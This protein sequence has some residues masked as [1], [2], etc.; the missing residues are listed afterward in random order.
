MR[1]LVVFTLVLS[2]ASAQAQLFLDDQFTVSVT[3][4]IVYGTGAV[5]NPSPGFKNLLLDLY[6]PAGAGVPALKPGFV[7]I[8]GGGFVSGDKSNGT[9]VAIANQF[10]RR[11]YVCVSIN[12]RLQGDDPP[13]P[14]DTPIERAIVAAIEDAGKAVQWMR[15]NAATYGIDINRIALGGGSAGAITSLFLGYGEYG[16]D[17]AVQAIM[18]LW[19]GL[20]GMESIVDANDPPVFI[21][22]GTNDAVVPYQ[23]SLDL[24]ARLDDVG[25]DYEFYPIAGAGHGVSLNTVVDGQTL[26]Q[27][28]IQFMYTHVVLPQTIP[29]SASDWEIFQ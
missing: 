26:M 5:Q 23:L 15:N 7:L 27:R 16:D 14:G 11:G 9:M 17:V 28:L 18:D 20:Y 6:E 1:W 25:L 21:V 2:A 3:N 13:T 22:H 4:D 8:H 12:Y 19:G 10:A 24:V 29:T